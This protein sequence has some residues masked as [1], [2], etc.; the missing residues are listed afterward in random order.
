MFALSMETFKRAGGSCEA[1]I[2]LMAGFYSGHFEM[3][4]KAENSPTNLKILC[5]LFITEP[6]IFTTTTP[7][8][9]ISFPAFQ[10]GF[11]GT[12]ILF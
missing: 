2:K 9:K 11:Y 7:S 3:A 12:F 6:F 4:I 10:N 5:L 1:G 8:I